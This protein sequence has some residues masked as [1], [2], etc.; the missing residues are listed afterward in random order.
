MTNKIRAALLGAGNRGALAYAPYALR[1]PQ[2]L[3]IVAV[4]E[5]MA[6]RREAFVRDYGIRSED[7]VADWRELLARPRLADAAIICTQDR[8]HTEPTLLAL[9]QGYHVLLEKPMSPEPSECVA[10]EHA[11]READRL[12]TICHVLRYTPFWAA[13][14]RVLDDKRIG[15]IMSVQLSENVG[16]YHI[17]HSFVRG[18]WSRKDDSSPMILAKSCHDMDILS[19][20]IDREC[21]RASS[22]GSLGHFR[23]ENAPAG[24]AARCIDGCAVEA[25]CAYSAL[26]QYLDRPG[27]ARYITSD[28]SLESV[29]QA[30]REGPYGRCVYRCDN[31]V[32]DHQVANF[33]F[34]GG[35]TA[36]FSMSGFT[37]NISRSIQV[38]GT[39]GELRGYMEKRAFT[40]YDFVTG[41]QQEM[42]V[43]QS[44]SGHGGG[45]EG[46]V[47][48]FLQEV[49]GY[50]SG[51]EGLT[52]ASASVRSHFMAFAAEES[53]LSGGKPVDLRE[54]RSRHMSAN[55]KSP[56]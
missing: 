16:F 26:K 55:V 46:I 2:E 30:L 32:V 34:E 13:V 11:A 23:A 50:G 39:K 43:A 56:S 18:S 19:W 42:T 35:V 41:E 52:S 25:S 40:V 7:A 14:K 54:L 5:P 4:A 31:D 21:I 28:S 17:A 45:D 51:R 15:D 36:T 33:E 8:M 44:S 20:L 53:R 1:Y 29:V 22:F 49:R 24:S 3:E 38:M 37:H 47:R 27:W 48:S 9:K 12:L 10:M 6:E